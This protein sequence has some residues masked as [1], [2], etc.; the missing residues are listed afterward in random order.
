MYL[1]LEFKTLAWWAD[2]RWVGWA[3]N[4][5]APVAARMTLDRLL[6]LNRTRRRLRWITIP[7]T[8]VEWLAA[9]F[10]VSAI[11]IGLFIALIRFVASLFAGELD[12]FNSLQELGENPL[13]L[14]VISVALLGLCLHGL[15]WLIVSPIE[16]E[17][18][19]LIA[20][21]TDP[22]L[23]TLRPTPR[24]DEFKVVLDGVSDEL[25]WETAGLLVTYDSVASRAEK[26]RGTLAKDRAHHLSTEEQQLLDEQQIALDRMQDRRSELATQIADSFHAAEAP[27][28]E[29][30][31]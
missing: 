12:E 5:D 19:S 4:P 2:A 23:S 29:E 24:I 26:L 22:E 6:V 25:A 17:R 9:L 3:V 7:L 28:T 11:F 14:Q 21:L 8:I 10:A 15:Q 20:K 31:S 27:I 18:K 30:L 13:F 1:D 16:R